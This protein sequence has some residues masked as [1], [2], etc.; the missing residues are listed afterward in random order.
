MVAVAGL[1]RMMAG[2][3][4]EAGPSLRQRQAGM[5]RAGGKDT[6]SFERLN[7]RLLWDI[8]VL[9]MTIWGSREI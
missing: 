6:F 5:S 8:P 9:G 2:H 4:R 7:L 3:G 1:V